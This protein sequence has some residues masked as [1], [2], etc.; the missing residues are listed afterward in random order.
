MLKQERKLFPSRSSSTLS[1][2]ARKVSR[3]IITS[4]AAPE[5]NKTILK[6]GDDELDRLVS[7]HYI[8]RTAFGSDFSAPIELDNKIVLDVGCGPATWTMEMANAYPGC[9]FIGIDKHAVFPRDIKPK[10]CHFQ[11]VDIANAVY[12]PFPDNSI[13]YIFQR[14][15]NWSLNKDDWAPLMQ[16][17][18]RILKPGGWI[19]LMESVSSF[20]LV[21]YIDN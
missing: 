1:G 10:N 9:T 14:D 11:L 15:M 2:S 12:L 13:D 21:F 18:F 8:L 17:Y 6:D 3:R 19:E 20:I 4:N 7:Q 16:E 5:T